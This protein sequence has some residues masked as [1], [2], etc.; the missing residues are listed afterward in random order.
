MSRRILITALLLLLAPERSEAF[1][2]MAAGA[3]SL[4]GEREEQNE[5][6]VAEAVIER[7]IMDPRG[8]V[9]GLILTGGVH[10]YVTSRAEAQV[11]NAL[12]AGD[13]VRVFGRRTAHDGLVQPDVIKNLTRG[14]T[15]VVP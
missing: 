4:A 11:T 2:G 5:G 9:E 3:L 14:T 12:K 10:M 8:E 13:L 7:Y 15:F 1:P 6:P